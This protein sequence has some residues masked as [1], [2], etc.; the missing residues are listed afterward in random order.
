MIQRLLINC[1]WESFGFESS[2]ELQVVA[3]GLEVDLAALEG[4][5]VE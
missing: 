1:V 5:R 3:V 4:V 2:G